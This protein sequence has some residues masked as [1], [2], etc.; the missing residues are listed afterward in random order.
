MN[1][2]TNQTSMRYNKTMDISL[3]DS[4]NEKMKMI[5]E[6]KQPHLTEAERLLITRFIDYMEG[7]DLLPLDE[8]LE[9]LW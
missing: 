1:V 6:G 2:L 3:H 5:V 9:N 8:P 7:R 4:A